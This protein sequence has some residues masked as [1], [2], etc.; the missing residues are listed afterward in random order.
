MERSGPAEGAGENALALSTGGRGRDPKGLS[1]LL[2]VVSSSAIVFFLL[3][4]TL[5]VWLSS[6]RA[7][8]PGTLVLPSVDH[9]ALQQR[10][11]LE[12]KRA[13]EAVA[14]KL[15]IEVRTVG[16]LFRRVGRAQGEKDSRRAERLLRD[17]RATTR[18]VLAAGEEE[19]LLRLRALQAELFREAVERASDEAEPGSELLELGGPFVRNA[20]QRFS[21]GRKKLA[22]SELE[23]NVLFRFRWGRLTGSSRHP[24]F[25]PSLNEQRAYYALLLRFPSASEPREQAAEQA[26]ASAA[27]G[28]LD[29]EFPVDA[30]VGLALARAGSLAEAEGYLARYQ[31][32]EAGGAFSLQV[33][34][35]LSL[36]RGRL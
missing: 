1:R 8:L 4:A 15:P 2:S 12:R 11:Q 3:V 21:H 27:L 23:L 30:A 36:V 24:Q 25:R 29:P 17:L 6:P 26:V 7:S 10:H 34:N 33:R 13:R 35:A 19:N 22:I 32:A 20:H 18:G 28:R 31:Q 16:E 14:E 5:S 9:Q